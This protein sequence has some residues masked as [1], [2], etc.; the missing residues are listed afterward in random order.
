MMSGTRN[1]FR[2]GYSKENIFLFFSFLFLIFSFLPTPTF[3]AQVDANWIGA[4][5]GS[6]NTGSNWSGGVV[7]NNSTDTYNVK[8]D[9]GNTGQATTVT[10]NTINPTVD[11]LT[12][13]SLDTFIV[14]NGR[15]FTVTGGSGAG[16]ITNNGTL[17]ID[18]SGSTT[19]LRITGATVTPVV[20]NGSGSIVL[21]DSA[22]GISSATVDQQLTNNS[23]IMGAGNV[24][25]NVLLITNTG[26]IVANTSGSIL[27]F[28]VPSVADAGVNT[29]YMGALS[30]G[31]LSLSTGSLTNTGGTIQAAL[32]GTVRLAGVNIKGGTID[33]FGTGAVDVTA[34]STLDTA[35][36]TVTVTGAGNMTLNNAV[37]LTITGG[38]LTNNSRI[39][40]AAGGAQTPL[41]FTGDT[42]INGTGDVVLA[43]NGRITGSSGVRLTLG[44]GQTVTMDG[45]TT[46]LG[47]NAFNVTN[48]GL[49]KAIKTGTTGNIDAP[50]G[51]EFFNTGTFRAED[52]GTMAFQPGLY[53]N[54]GGV[55][56][57]AT[58]SLVT[59]N[60]LELEGGTLT[61]SGTHR[62][63]TNASTLDGGG[64]AI[65]IA[66]GAR[67]EQNNG[68]AVTPIGTI[69]LAG[70]AEWHSLT[71]GFT[72][73][74]D[75]GTNSVTLNGTGRFLLGSGGTLANSSIRATGGTVN[76][77]SSLTVEGVGGVGG[78]AGAVSNTGLILANVSGAAISL[79][80][81]VGS[82]FTNTGTE[83]ASG[84][85]IISLASGSHNNTGGITE[86]L[87]GS[88]VNVVGGATLTGGTY[89]TS[90]TG[91]IRFTSNTPRIVGVTFGSGANVIQESD[92][93][94]EMSGVITNNGSIKNQPA[95]LT[96]SLVAITDTTLAGTGR[97]ILGEGTTST[98]GR[99]S[100]LGGTFNLNNATGHTIEGQGII[101]SLLTIDNDGTINAN[102]SGLTLTLDTPATTI[103]GDGMFK[104]SSGGR[105]L[106]SDTLTGT[107]TSSLVVDASS[108][109]E[110]GAI[111]VTVGSA[112]INGTLD[113]NGGTLTTSGNL[114]VGST[115]D[116]QLAS[117]LSVGGNFS[118][119][120]TDETLWD[121]DGPTAFLTMTGGIGQ[122]QPANI[123]T[124]EIGGSDFGDDPHP[125]TVVPDAAGF[126]SNFD[127]TTL[128]IGANARVQ[129]VDSINNGN[130]NGE[131]AAAEA[132]YVDTL[133]LEA[134]S[135]LYT[136]GLNLYYNT[137]NLLGGGVIDDYITNDNTYDELND[138]S[139]GNIA[140]DLL[141]GTADPTI[142][143]NTLTGDG[144]TTMV[145][146]TNLP[147]LAG[148]GFVYS[149]SNAVYYDI[150]TT[151]PFTG[152]FTVTFD[153]DGLTGFA[154]PNDIFGIHNGT[155]VFGTY[156]SGNNTYSFTANSFS[157]FGL[158]TTPEPS[159]L[160]LMLSGLFGLYR[161][162]RYFRK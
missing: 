37:T 100:G 138:V 8:I 13:D 74:F 54:T 42:T 133:T 130:R 58:S 145:L 34:S 51:G 88:T 117:G 40:T 139:P 29:G 96:L 41:N 17:S 52:F 22:S 31:I 110:W 148:Y 118:F 73:L 154:S 65:T 36:A 3:A 89:N 141:E 55:I 64:T 137:A 25:G 119:A 14:A 132:L 35:G 72:T 159:T 162:R 161:Y 76:L 93:N 78:N 1:V 20:I 57:A 70:T 19:Q 63:L 116:L 135:K 26:S 16:T 126:V 84:G 90:G 91:E 6:Y 106:V 97:V 157:D 59:Y 107:S 39:D 140:L 127:I 56:E 82:A 103:G 95:G 62:F 134:G 33:I 114:T 32:S 10:L 152:S 67:V 92:T 60:G 124:L 53:D 104:A 123:P 150:T 131:F 151:A 43:N 160:L 122:S 147:S 149:G 146:E 75:G 21:G 50:V 120:L 108:E 105:L 81:G 144:L 48:Q 46:S 125:G 79:D 24:G 143:W 99:L 49:V 5:S 128:T 94:I 47:N 129:L 87:T 155:I 38:T 98:L 111:N 7:P 23:T 77:G 9:N 30:G 86:A 109:A 85:G 136:N 71:G 11:N 28:D 153:L 12:I 27:T 101:G 156:N 18:S 4:A 2:L 158:G 102:R 68:I 66:S 80:P 61:G 45:T 44:S 113:I 142:L 15:L 83:R 115:A 69:T 112:T 121:L